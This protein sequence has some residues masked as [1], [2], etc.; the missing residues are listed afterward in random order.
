MIVTFKS[1]C[2]CVICKFFLLVALDLTGLSCMVIGFYNLLPNKVCWIGYLGTPYM[3]VKS[4]SESYWIILS[5]DME[6]CNSDV[7]WENYIARE[8]NTG[9]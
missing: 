6:A 7:G 2:V 9:V 8:L 1:S 4:P 5:A 3:T